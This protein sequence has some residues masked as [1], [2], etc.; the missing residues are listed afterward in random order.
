MRR[1][2]Q[3]PKYRKH[4]RSGQA[5]VTV[6]GSG[7]RVIYLG[8]FNSPES[9][10]RYAEVL[11]A[12]AAGKATPQPATVF[13]PGSRSYTVGRLALEYLEHAVAYYRDRSG[14]PTSQ[15]Y[16]TR[17]ALALLVEMF[18]T[19][20]VEE[21]GPKKLTAF[22]SALANRGLSRTT[23]A[24]YLGVV[25]RAVRWAVCEEKIPGTVRHALEAVE[26]LK[27][28]RSNAAEPRKVK[29]AP[30]EHVEAVLGH[31]APVLADVVRLQLA[32]GARPGEVLSMR[33]C[34]I[35]QSAD[36]W[37][38]RPTTHKT[39]WKGLERTIPIG[40]MLQAILETYR[41]RPEDE[42]LFS[43]RVAAEQ[44]AVRKRA[45][46]KSKVWPSHQRRYE[47]QRKARPKR[48]PGDRYTTASYGRAVRR[49]CEAAGVPLWHVHQ[50]RHLYGTEAR[51]LFGLEGAQA[52]LGH[53]RA[54]V[55]EIYAERSK[56]LAAS[57]AAE[58]E[59]VLL[60]KSRVGQSTPP[61]TRIAA[62]IG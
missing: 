35:D 2:V 39:A 34:E 4:L 47:Q 1:G 56:T 18:E 51:R 28:G 52:G 6:P 50:L 30:V 12:W 13:S 15:V 5:V 25:R 61:A 60:L 27:P 19:V 11:A 23:V 59:R 58:M 31:L 54:D 44:H 45:A 24:E 46:R 29:P 37:Q 22:Q 9:R 49:A 53:Q 40:P 55:S 8:L 57:V 43:P 10:T 41:D 16:P 7:G 36:V 33:W 3:V 26:N 48:A 62:E 14:R 38:Y 21:F 17:R 42:F 20:E 32:T